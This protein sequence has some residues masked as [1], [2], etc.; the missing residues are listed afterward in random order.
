MVHKGTHI[1]FSNMIEGI[2]RIQAFA[3]RNTRTRLYHCKDPSALPLAC[4]RFKGALSI[5]AGFA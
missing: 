3:A 1:L 2:D 4:N 5:A